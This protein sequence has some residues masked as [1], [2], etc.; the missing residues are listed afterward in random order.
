M[1]KKILTL[2]I[3]ANMV[4]AY[5]WQ[6]EVGFIDN[7]IASAQ[8]CI[9]VVDPQVWSNTD[10]LRSCAN[11]ALNYDGGS[12]MFNFQKNGYDTAMAV[13]DRTNEELTAIRALD[14]FNRDKDQFPCV[15]MD[16]YPAVHF[17]Q[18]YTN[19]IYNCGNPKY[20]DAPITTP[21]A[22]DDFHYDRHYDYSHCSTTTLPRATTTVP[23]GSCLSGY[24]GKKNGH[25]PNSYCYKTSDDCD[26]TC[27]KG[28]R[29]VHP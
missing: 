7:S 12:I 17:G 4:S 2:A 22:Y 29:G 5:Y 15:K 18:P 1:L 24:K 27:V 3:F 11:V 8:L 13:L 26:D 19:K 20:Y 16:E 9:T 23:A 6:A 25:R 10:A 14:Q 21:T 28:I